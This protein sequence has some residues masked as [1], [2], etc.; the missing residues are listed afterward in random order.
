V[1]AILIVDD[2]FGI[3]DSLA[4]VLSE[5]GF[6][7]ST[8]SNG[9]DALR[10][11]AEQRPDLILMDYMMPVMDGA[12]TLQAIRNDPA[13]RDLP[14]L[15]M[16]SVPKANLP[17]QCAPTGFLRKPFDIDALLSMLATLLPG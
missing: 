7:V 12:E 13:L 10:R 9:K 14:V 17:A 2:E 5:E 4:E 6:A 15:L 3:V 16:S 1:K 8:A 11:I